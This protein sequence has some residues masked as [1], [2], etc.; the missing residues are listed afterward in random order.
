MQQAVDARIAGIPVLQAL[1]M[2]GTVPATCPEQGLE[3]IAFSQKSKH[4]PTPL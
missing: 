4:Q 2:A 1:S 3:F